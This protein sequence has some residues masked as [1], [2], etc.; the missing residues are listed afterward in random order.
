MYLR[1]FVSALLLA[2]GSLLV[3]GQPESGRI[4][5]TFRDI[6]L[7]EAISA[8]E[9]AGRYTF[10]YDAAGLDLSVKVSLAA[11]NMPLMEALDTMLSPVSVGY[12][13]N[14]RQI[15]LYPD[16]V[17]GGYRVITGTVLD[18]GGQPIPGVAVMTSRAGHGVSAGTD[19]KFSIRTGPD[20]QSLTFSCLGYVE[21][22][23]T[24]SGKRDHITVYLSEDA[25]SLDATVVVGYGT[26]KKVNLTGAISVVES[27]E[28]KDRISPTL[29]H[30]LQGTVPGLN[31][32]TSSGRPGNGASINIRGVNSINGGSPLVLVDGVEGDLDQVNPNDVESISVVKDASSAAIY[33]ARASF[34]VVLVTTKSGEGSDGRPTVKYSGR[35]GWTEPTMSTDFETRGYYSVYLI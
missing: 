25:I 7:G 22:T 20:E 13:I 8:V 15:V 26:Q 33:G 30:M 3:W 9:S 12:E 24:L 23:V 5:V 28:L 35:F 4:T 29:S 2:M 6:P 19:G 18:T 32:S 21:K 14:G 11:E 34:G 27:D 16:V 10:L 1:S 31:I 17:D